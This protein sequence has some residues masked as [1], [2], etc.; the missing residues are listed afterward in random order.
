MRQ[1]INDDSLSEFLVK[2]EGHLLQ[3]YCKELKYIVKE[4]ISDKIPFELSNILS[5]LKK[6]HPEEFWE[7]MISNYNFFSQVIIDPLVSFGLKTV[8][9]PTDVKLLD[10]LKV[11]FNASKYALSFY[12]DNVIS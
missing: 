12:S 3:Y 6:D 7:N 8:G 11:C 1:I 5:S 2:H 9:P 10:Q 4:N